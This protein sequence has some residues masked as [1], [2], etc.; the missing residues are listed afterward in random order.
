MLGG[1]LLLLAPVNAVYALYSLLVLLG[2][3]AAMF[4]L[5]RRWLA[6]PHAIVAAVFYVVNPYMLLCLYQRGAAAEM[7]T[8]AV[9]PLVLLFADRLPER[10]AVAG[11]ALAFAACW[12]TD[13]PAAVVASYGLALAVVVLAAARRSWRV[14]LYGAGALALGLALAAFC[15]LPAAYEQ[16]WVPIEE[17]ISP[18]YRPENWEFTWGYDQT[19]GWFYAMVSGLVYGESA[20]AVVGA[21]LALRRSRLPRGVALLLAVMVAACV[22]ML[23]PWAGVLWMRLPKLEFVQFPWRLLFVLST[24]LTVLLTAAL[25]RWR[26]P[27]GAAVLLLLAL[28]GALPSGIHAVWHPGAPAELQQEIAENHGYAADP[29]FLPNEADE[30][31]VK[32]AGNA[33]EVALDEPAAQVKLERWAPNHKRFVVE[34]G[35]PVQATLRLLDYPGWEAAANGVR[36]ATDHNRAGQLTLALPP[37]RSEVEVRFVRTADH[38]AGDG[39]SLAAAA[40]WL[41]LLWGG[42]RRRMTSAAGA[43]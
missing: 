12:L 27:A 36:L 42:R 5:A 25:A 38:L 39:L 18:D 20:L 43:H 1:W 28:A 33:P 11:L 9:F 16:R 40:L 41:A 2:A 26:W 35:A 31:L 6:G 17:M 21:L 3:G 37:G 22:L 19:G 14:L 24:A 32:A 8:G 23:T 34:A 7:M 15:V 30:D 13:L 4:A 10:R 29:S